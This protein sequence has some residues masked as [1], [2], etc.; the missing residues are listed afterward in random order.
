[1]WLNQPTYTYW[2]PSSNISVINYTHTPPSVSRY[3]HFHLDFSIFLRSLNWILS[4]T[5]ALASTTTSYPFIWIET[6]HALCHLFQKSILYPL[7]LQP[8]WTYEAALAFDSNPQFD[9]HQPVTKLLS[10]Y[11]EDFSSIYLFLIVAPPH[12]S[13]KLTCFQRISLLFLQFCLA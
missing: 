2:F 5:F 12:H 8:H 3:C 10:F 11:N 13:Y 1:M 6:F 4:F 9:A 7:P